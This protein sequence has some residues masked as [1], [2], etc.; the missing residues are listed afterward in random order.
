MKPRAEFLKIDYFFLTVVLI[1]FII[2]LVALSSAS[3]VI[4]FEQSGSNYSLFLRQII[5]GAVPG[6]ILMYLFSRINYHVWQKLAPLL[7]LIGIV[8]LVLVLV[9]GIGFKT[10]NARRWINFGF[11]LFQPAEFL[12]LATVFYLASWYDKR[13][14]QAQDLYYGFLP[15]LV[16]V[17]LIAGLIILQP[18]LGTMLVLAGIAGIMFFIGGV[19]LKYLLSAA[20]GGLLV[21]WLLIKAAPYRM[22]RFLAFFDPNADTRGVTYQI[23][24][25]L[26][27]I[28][29]GGW[30]GVGIGQSRQKFNYLP[31]PMGDSIFAIMAEE[32]G[33]IRIILVL[34]MFLLFAYKGYKISLAAPDT[35]G[36]LVAV[37]ITS[38]IVLQALI[39]IGGITKAIPL[40]GI[41][42]PLIS[43]GSSALVVTFAAIGVLLNISRYAIKK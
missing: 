29:S 1:I 13:Q 14:Q 33:F 17:G 34:V 35:F 7:I 8:L 37:G 22:N 23:Y 16:I 18:D 30:W 2:G 38:W 21:F 12:K 26:I 5:Y 10:G 9:P 40:T 27:A 43:Y 36:K 41:P 31:E 28:G 6:L 4:S 20:G 32:L 24:Q 11:F 39:N 15:S 42:L 3:T 25:A 19:R